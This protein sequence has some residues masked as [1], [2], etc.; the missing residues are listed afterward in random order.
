MKIS[1]MNNEQA[2]EALIRLAAPFGNICDDEK[3]VA[4]ID[5][6]DSM[7]GIPVIQRIGRILPQVATYALKEHK[8]D[9]FEIVGALTAK[10]QNQVAKMNFMET[11]NVLKES[12]DEVLHGFFTSSVEQIKKNA[13][14][15]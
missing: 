9:L 6:Y 3:M 4:L 10:N 7:K 8:S 2:T 12:Y 5:N 1:E 13:G 11:I 14:A 15:S